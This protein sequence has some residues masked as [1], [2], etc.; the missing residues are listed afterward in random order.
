MIAPHRGG[1]DVTGGVGDQLRTRGGELAQVGADGVQHGRHRLFVDLDPQRAKFL[2]NEVGAFAGLGDARAGMHLGTKRLQLVSQRF[3]SAAA[4][5]HHYQDRARRD[6]GGSRS[7]QRG[8]V[9]TRFRGG[10]QHDD[11]LVGEQRRAEQFGELVGADVAGPH[12]AYRH[13]LAAEEI[14]WLGARPLARRPQH[15]GYRSLDQQFLVAQHQ[16]QW[17]N[18]THHTIVSRRADLSRQGL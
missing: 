16:M 10:F 5:V 18:L 3:G 2:A 9:L 13:V 17:R 14:A 8:G 11:P 7:D 6:V 12:A 15:V 1:I 4:R